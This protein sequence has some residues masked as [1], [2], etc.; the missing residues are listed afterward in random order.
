MTA[1]A[2][3]GKSNISESVLVEQLKYLVLNGSGTI[4]KP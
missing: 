3:F 4:K 2:A 1:L